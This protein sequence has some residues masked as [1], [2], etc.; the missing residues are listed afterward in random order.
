VLGVLSLFFGGW[1]VFGPS[2]SES[3]VAAAEAAGEKIRTSHHVATGLW[4]AALVNL[5]VCLGLIRCVRWLVHPLTEKP[6]RFSAA[7][8]DRTSSSSRPILIAV[9]A[10]LGLTLFHAGPRLDDGLWHDE[11]K[12][13]KHFVVGRYNLSKTSGEIRY[14]EVT[15][16]E[17]VW[18]FTFPNHTLFG[19]LAKASHTAMPPDRTRDDRFYV[20]ETAIRLPSLLGA[21]GGIVAT[22]WLLHLLGLSR[23]AMIAPLLLSIHPWFL[24]YAAEARGYSL[25][26]LFGP[27][28]IALAI[29]GLNDGR[30]RWWLALALCQF[31]LVW[32]VLNGLYLLIALNVS[33]AIWLWTKR[34]HPATRALA[35]R[36]L[37][38]GITSAVIAVWMM[39][40]LL[41]QFLEYVAREG[42]DPSKYGTETMRDM[43][44]AYTTGMRY[45]EFGGGGGHL[46]G[47]VPGMLLA[48]LVG[49]LAI[50]GAWSLARRNTA[51]RIALAML[52]LPAPLFY[53]HCTISQPHFFYWYV[54]FG[55]P[56]FWAVV[57]QGCVAA[58]DACRCKVPRP[59]LAMA[60]V[61][62][63]AML[64]VGHGKRSWLSENPI[65][66]ERDAALAV[67]GSFV[68][69]TL[70]EFR[71]IVT[72]GFCREPIL[73]DIS[74]ARASDAGEFKAALIRADADNKPLYVNYGPVKAYQHFGDIM[75][76][77]D[78]P[79]MFEPIADFEGIDAGSD[80]VVRR[81]RP[82]SVATSEKP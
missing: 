82:G 62:G 57:A 48:A 45:S 25:L 27:L 66:A 69:P 2:P 26:F 5:V 61:L 7:R 15:W 55:L 24:R 13:V 23:A 68:D 71:N 77:V 16:Q 74:T 42:K 20:N 78:D 75:E 3:G 1:L 29:K 31:L 59:A 40:P 67:R 72:L 6:P 4:R 22:A 76:L 81:Y 60:L 73:Y 44:S 18:R 8:N 32:S 52:L 46:R 37:L 63:L 35:G 21:L 33:L 65:E 36:W 54:I 11:A 49:G 64:A 38:S 9:L 70:P 10:A 43:L 80:R 53:A 56:L 14:H 28:C 34:S 79:R 39:M 41:P 17:A 58:G 51:A 50:V 19:V 47:N 12:G 30:W